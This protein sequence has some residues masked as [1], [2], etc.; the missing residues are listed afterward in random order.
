[1]GKEE[2]IVSTFLVLL[3]EDNLV[4]AMRLSLAL[5]PFGY[6]VSVARTGHEAVVAERQFR[7]SAVILDLSLPDVSGLEVCQRLREVSLV[8]IVVVTATDD[9]QAHLESLRRGADDV[10]VKPVDPEEL[11]LRL[12]AIIRR[13]QGGAPTIPP[14]YHYRGL[15]I[16]FARHRT[17]MH[18]QELGLTPIDQRLLEALARHPG[19][20]RS[21][22][23]L[24][25]EV[26][27]P[28][29]EAQ[30]AT[31]YLQISRLRQKLGEKRGEPV[32]LF[33]RSRIGYLVPAPE[34]FPLPENQP[35]SLPG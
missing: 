27:G 7:P 32:Y 5:A 11:R 35:A 18:G 4:E 21:S 20:V 6:E 10:L 26:W 34:P 1:M 8:P 13:A 30:Y 25:I 14:A 22:D 31:L 29:A 28:H 23:D 17:A 9:H 2:H 3:V 19:T 16:D 12:D 15:K 33:T 24:L